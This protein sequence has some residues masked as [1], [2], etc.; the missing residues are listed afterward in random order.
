M[1]NYFH[2]RNLNLQEENY[3]YQDT[4]NQI[5]S[6]SLFEKTSQY[7]A[8]WRKGY[9]NYVYIME[10]SYKTDVMDLNTHIHVCICIC[11]HVHVSEKQ[12]NV[13]KY[14]QWGPL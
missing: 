7:S 14:L 1:E 13:L 9:H 4:L 12:G 5:L 2:S 11:L 8:N 10:S 6:N 3:L